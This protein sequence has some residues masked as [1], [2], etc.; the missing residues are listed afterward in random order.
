M[1]A[2][3]RRLVDSTRTFFHAS[4]DARAECANCATVSA[5]LLAPWRTPRRIRQLLNGHLS[6][7]VSKLVRR[8]GA[9]EPAV[10]AVLRKMESRNE[11]YLVR[12]RTDGDVFM[13]AEP[14][15][16]R[17]A[18]RLVVSKVRER[19]ERLGVVIDL[20][21]WQMPIGPWSWLAV[22]VAGVA[23]SVRLSH[24]EL[25]AW[26]HGPDDAVELRVTETLTGRRRACTPR[27][28]S[29]RAPLAVALRR[30]Y[31]GGMCDP[32]TAAARRRRTS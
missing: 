22:Q 29:D 14:F 31:A 19:A 2:R 7:A 30:C 13:Q 27:A 6:L 12:D 5:H 9:P 17:V 23:R 20:V 32:D 24:A 26:A 10:R 28:G 25:L 18:K 3:R 4:A 21:E 16:T 11:G 1:G 8:S 15:D